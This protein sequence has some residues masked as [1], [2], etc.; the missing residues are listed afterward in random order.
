MHW[1]VFNHFL[2]TPAHHPAAARALLRNVIALPIFS[3]LAR[4]EELITE[5]QKELDDNKKECYGHLK[6][7]QELETVQKHVT[8]R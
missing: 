1:Q 2:P 7:I 5:I 6:V 4:A 8:E 3:D